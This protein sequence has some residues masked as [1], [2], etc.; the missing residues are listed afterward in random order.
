MSR[1]WKLYTNPVFPNCYGVETETGSFSSI[2]ITKEEAQL[3][4][5]APELLEKLEQAVFA[6]RKMGGF[7][8]AGQLMFLISAEQTIAKAKGGSV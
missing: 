4:A 5:T 7:A 1:K 2:Q 8:K 6:I 3:M